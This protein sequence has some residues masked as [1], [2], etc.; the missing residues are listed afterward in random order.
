M[1]FYQVLGL[2]SLMTSS[3]ICTGSFV[4]DF[5]DAMSLK[6]NV[7]KLFFFAYHF[8]PMVSCTNTWSTDNHCAGAQDL[9]KSRSYLVIVETQKS[10]VYLK[11]LFRVWIQLSGKKC[12][13]LHLGLPLEAECYIKPC[14]TVVLYQD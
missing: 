3:S 5:T 10:Q 13:V 1:F 11:I 7:D 8:K 14:F 12:T 6:L 9:I 2:F 4:E